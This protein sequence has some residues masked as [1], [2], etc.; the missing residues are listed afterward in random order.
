M[1][2]MS[3]TRV[4]TA[5]MVVDHSAG[6]V[7]VTLAVLG[8]AVAVGRPDMTEGYQV[9]SGMERKCERGEQLMW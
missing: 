1:H 7:M 4:L 2:T 3:W 6:M 5:L 8:S 9:D